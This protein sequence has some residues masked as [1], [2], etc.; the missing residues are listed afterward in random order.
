MPV[1]VASAAEAA[2]LDREAIAAGA[3]S[4]GLMRVA[5]ANAATVIATRYAAPLRDGVTVYAGAGNNGGDGW[6]LAAALAHAGVRVHVDVAAEPHTED[7]RAEAARARES[8]ELGE[9]P[10]GVAVDALLGIGGTGRMTGAVAEGAARLQARRA[11]GATLVA[12]DVPSGLNATS[13]ED[14]GCVPAALTISFGACR[15][16]T[17]VSRG[18][19]GEVAVVDIGLGTI[20]G[21]LP[22]L[23]DATWVRGRVPAIAAD[24]NKGTRRRVAVVAGAYG[25]GG[26]A[27]SAGEGALGAGAGLVKIA[28]DPAVVG[29]ANARLPEALTATLDEAASE[30]VAGWSDA[31]VIG[32]GLG[33][34]PDVRALVERVVRAARGP[35]VLDADALNTY[36]GDIPAL[37]ALLAGRAAVLTPHPAEFA[38]L[39]GMTVNDVLAGRFDAG[40][41]VAA[42][43]GAA[44][45]LKG[46]PT[47]VTAPDGTVCVV[48]RGTPLLAT[49]GSGDVLGGMIA[50]LLAQGMPPGDAA[51]CAAWV[52]GR[53]AE[54]V[55]P[56]VRGRTLRDVITAL[57]EAWSAVQEFSPAYPVLALLPA[58]P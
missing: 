55:V 8:V 27:L 17:L 35:V 30:A 42:A 52:H 46:T 57:P 14:T 37:A 40:R 34:G 48:P 16:G 36:A 7:A 26:A 10:C 41:A 44:V 25:M 50:T 12:L 54:L 47:V 18:V 3:P 56:P 1:R 13:G 58:V 11:A 43:T 2:A 38:R 6:C 19:C 49:G 32:P 22:V 45:L 51:A 20:G 9:A 28:S 24:A 39:T 23:V 31:L 5:A 4:R 53:A 15:R 33:H 21:G 29:A